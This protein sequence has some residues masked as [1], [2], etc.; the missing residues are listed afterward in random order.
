MTRIDVMNNLYTREESLFQ[1]NNEVD[2]LDLIVEIKELVKYPTRS[3]VSG[4]VISLVLDK[5]VKVNPSN[6]NELLDVMDKIIYTLC[7]R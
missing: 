3:K 1:I 6:F 2:C 7:K 5:V 4:I